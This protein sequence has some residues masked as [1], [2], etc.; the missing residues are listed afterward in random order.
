MQPAR[1][2]LVTLDQTMTAQQFVQRYPSSVPAEQVYVMNG[3][4]ATTSLSRGTL[5]KR[6]VGGIGR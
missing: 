2:E 3:V 1:V 6:V 4:E 5:V